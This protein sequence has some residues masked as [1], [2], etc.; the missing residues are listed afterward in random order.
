MLELFVE[1]RQAVSLIQSGA[2]VGL[3]K[4][5]PMVLIAEVIRQHHIGDL[6]VIGVPTAGLGVDLLVASGA[7]KSIETGAIHLDEYGHAPNVHRALE[8]NRI[9]LLES[10]CP[11]IELALHAGSCGV[12]FTA[13]PGLFGSDILQQR[14]DFLIITDPYDATKRVVIVPAITPDVALIHGLRADPHGNVVTTI[15]SDDRLLAQASRRVIAS[16]EEVRENALE[17]LSSSEQI[18]PATYFDAIVVAPRGAYPLACPGYYP[19]DSA[20]LSAYIRAASDSGLMRDYL[21]NFVAT[22]SK[23]EAVAHRDASLAPK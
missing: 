16:I 15:D 4:M 5:Y 6:R 22:R 9:E 3:G 1:A 8:D 11:V 18:I 21:R 12:S 13:I 14:R 17:S 23:R 2:S 7:V 20:E 19:A 10:A